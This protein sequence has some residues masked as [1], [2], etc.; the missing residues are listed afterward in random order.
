MSHRR[1]VRDDRIASQIMTAG[2]GGVAI[3]DKNQQ[4][5]EKTTSVPK[6]KGRIKVVRADRRE[7]DLQD[8]FIGL[9]L[10]LILSGPSLNTHN[11]PLIHE[12]GAFSFGVNNSWSIHR[13]TFWTCADP[14]KKFLSQGWLDPRILKFVPMGKEK[15]PIRKKAGLTFQDSGIQTKDCPNVVYYP[16]NTDFDHE[17]FLSEITVNWG[18]QGDKKDSLGIKGGRSVMLSAIRLSYYLGF[19]RIYL[20]GCDFNM[21]EGKQN[22][23]FEQERS[24]GAV[25]GNNNT[26]NALVKRFEALKPVFSK[27]GLSLFNCNP[28]SKLKLFPY[29]TLE[30][31]IEDFRECLPKR[32]NTLGWYDPPKKELKLRRV[33]NDG[34]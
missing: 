8:Q 22:Y 7:V 29:R 27:H 17:H 19:R 14:A 30:D 11:L 5:S 31:G 6:I 18:N 4:V 15:N 21:E 34:Q 2:R 26:Y 20:L 13:P 33:S 9:P 1:P 12:V 10:F 25:I 24:K 16:R 32:E 23:A 3:H 28:K